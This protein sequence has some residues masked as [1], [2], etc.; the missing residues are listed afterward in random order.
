MQVGTEISVFGPKVAWWMLNSIITFTKTK[1]VSFSNAREIQI[2]SL[3]LLWL[4]R[5]YIYLLKHI[6][7]IKWSVNSMN[8]STLAAIWVTLAFIISVIIAQY[9]QLPW[10]FNSF[11]FQL[12]LWLY[13]YVVHES[14]F[15]SWY[16]S[17][18]VKLMNIYAT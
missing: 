1:M 13:T 10:Q 18:S 4:I 12:L 7:K 11:I 8:S 16:N 5:A 14:D 6:N 17:F 9:N 3:Y 2:M 15:I